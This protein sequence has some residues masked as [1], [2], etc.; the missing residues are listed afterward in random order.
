MALIDVMYFKAIAFARKTWKVID[1][2]NALKDGVNFH[3]VLVS[4]C[5]S[6]KNYLWYEPIFPVCQNRNKFCNLKGTWNV[7]Y[8]SED[9]PCPCKAGFIG[10]HC[11]SCNKEEGFIPIDGIEGQIDPNTDIGI[12]CKGKLNIYFLHNCMKC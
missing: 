2:T 8:S 1:V 12:D 7:C 10:D 4:F 6:P 5:T 11:E 3:I 9:E